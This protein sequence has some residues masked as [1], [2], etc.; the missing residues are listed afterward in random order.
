MVRMRS[1]VRIWLSAPKKQSPH[2]GGCFFRVGRFRTGDLKCEAFYNQRTAPQGAARQFE[3][4]YQLQLFSLETVLFRGFLFF[5]ITFQSKTLSGS[6]QAKTARG[7]KTTKKL[8]CGDPG[9][10]ARKLADD[11]A[12]I[13]PVS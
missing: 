12:C 9:T 2:R 1:P 4:G 11:R 8:L 7:T 5:L 6:E 10:G 13:D 3:S